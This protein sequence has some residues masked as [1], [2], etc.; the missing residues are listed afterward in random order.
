MITIKD[1]VNNIVYAQSKNE[2]EVVNN[3]NLQCKEKFEWILDNVNYCDEEDYQE[4][5]KLYILAT[6]KA[7]RFE[8]IISVVKLINDTFDS[9]FIKI[10]KQ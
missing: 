5:K 2:E 8:N 4:L 7:Y 10:L 3:W 6:D 1:V 9:Q